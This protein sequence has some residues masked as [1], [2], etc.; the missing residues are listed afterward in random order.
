[1]AYLISRQNG[2]GVI[3]YPQRRNIGEN[4]NMALKNGVMAK[5]SV[6]RNMATISKR[7]YEMAK[8]ANENEIES[9]IWQLA[10]AAMANQLN[11][12]MAAGEIYQWRMAAQCSISAM[13]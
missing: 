12:V 2:N 8:A 11:N 10:M 3:S 9:N 5:I 7:K 13:A 6:Y 1:M 4:G